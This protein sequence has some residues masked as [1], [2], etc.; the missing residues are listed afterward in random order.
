MA[1][2]LLVEKVVEIEEGAGAVDHP[3]RQA[4]VAG[5]AKPGVASALVVGIV[6]IARVHR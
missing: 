2:V 6:R 4:A 1:V 3:A 5:V